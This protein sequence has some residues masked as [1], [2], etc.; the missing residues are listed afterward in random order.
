MAKPDYDLIEQR[1]KDWSPYLEKDEHWSAAAVGLLLTDQA[2]LL[3][4]C[5]EL[6][7]Q[8]ASKDDR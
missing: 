1:L 6:E 4:R 7:D 3:A 5:R 8:P 2:K